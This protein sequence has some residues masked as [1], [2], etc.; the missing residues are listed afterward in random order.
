MDSHIFVCNYHESSGAASD[1]SVVVVFA[2]SGLIVSVISI[3]FISLL[4]IG[5]VV[6]IL[7]QFSQNPVC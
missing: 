6:S 4:Q 1:G 5:Q 7:L 2:S 3:L